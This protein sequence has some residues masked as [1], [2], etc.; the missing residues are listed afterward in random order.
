[1][2]ELFVLV[3]ALILLSGFPGYIF[4]VL[5]D[6]EIRNPLNVCLIAGSSYSLGTLGLWS[7]Y[8]AA[9]WRNPKKQRFAV[10][11]GVAC[12]AIAFVCLENLFNMTGGCLK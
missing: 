7:L 10:V 1:M 4:A 3:P 5:S 8:D 2:K 9:R 11:F 6:T 12:V